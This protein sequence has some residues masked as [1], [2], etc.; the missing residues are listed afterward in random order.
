M[1]NVRGGRI[2]YWVNIKVNP[3]RRLVMDKQQYQE[4][5][6]DP[7]AF[8]KYTLDDP[9]PLSPNQSAKECSLIKEMQIEE[10]TTR[11]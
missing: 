10:G 11:D 1:K 3:E 8:H 6:R 4:T 9:Y 2:V 5:L 7:V